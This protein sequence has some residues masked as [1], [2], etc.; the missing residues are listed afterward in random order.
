M[1]AEAIEQWSAQAK[2]Q[3]HEMSHF[4]MAAGLIALNV[5]QWDIKLMCAKQRYSALNLDPER[6]VVAP[7]G[8]RLKLNELHARCKCRGE[9]TK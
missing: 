9:V 1:M 7:E 8:I 4:V 5:G 3:R 2:H 6:G